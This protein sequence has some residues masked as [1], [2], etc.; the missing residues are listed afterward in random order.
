MNH[1]NK[2][3]IRNVNI[4]RTIYQDEP[5]F[6]LQDRLKLTE[7]AIVLPQVLGP[8]A[9]LCDGLHTLSEIK[10]ALETQYGLHLPEETIENLLGQ[11]DEALLLEGETFERV[12]QAAIVEYR[13]APFRQPAL[14]GPS[15]PADP[16][17]LRRM[18][19]TYLDEAPK[20][21]T[22]SP[23]S[24]GIISPHIDYQRGG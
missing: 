19:Q 18:L 3:K 13:A 24:R 16:N 4:Q 8:L 15:Y 7:A 21:S 23:A 22:A 2:P 17:A 14:A 10:A 6:L 11:F 5:V 12:K 1:H 20:T 9:M